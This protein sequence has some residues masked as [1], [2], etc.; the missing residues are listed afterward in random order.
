MQKF[1]I[2]GTATTIIGADA[3]ALT[4]LR[5]VRHEFVR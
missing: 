3:I 2:I 5:N 4:H 1:I